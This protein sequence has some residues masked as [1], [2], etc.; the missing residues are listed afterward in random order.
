MNFI[1]APKRD[2][3]SM[4]LQIGRVSTTRWP[5]CLLDRSEILLRQSDEP[6]A[7]ITHRPVFRRPPINVMI[8]VPIAH[9]EDPL[10]PIALKSYA[11]PVGRTIASRRRCLS[12][13]GTPKPR[14][15]FE[16]R[17]HCCNVTC[18]ERTLLH[19]GEH[20]G[21]AAARTTSRLRY[22]APAACPHFIQANHDGMLEGS[23]PHESNDRLVA[24]RITAER[25]LLQSLKLPGIPLSLEGIDSW[26]EPRRIRGAGQSDEP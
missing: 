11:R 13:G 2:Q 12:A 20:P 21:V 17:A 9:F 25:L 3:L 8:S 15:R 23:Q 19:R 1:C 24:G 16:Q 4:C 14:G 5:R 18:G 26:K 7:D 10:R 6:L 22:H